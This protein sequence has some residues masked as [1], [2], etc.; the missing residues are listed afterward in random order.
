MYAERLTRGDFL[1]VNTYGLTDN[2]YMC[3]A[4]GLR[5]WTTERFQTLT[6]KMQLGAALNM[7]GVTEAFHEAGF[8]D[9]TVYPE[10][11]HADGFTLNQFESFLDERIRTNDGERFGLAFT[12][13]DRPGSHVITARAWRDAGS[14]R[15]FLST[16]FQLAPF[17]SRRFWTDIPK[18][19]SLSIGLSSQPR[20]WESLGKL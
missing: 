4:A 8:R 19:T 14:I 20:L 10:G 12:H 13:G 7:Q 11:H 18:A 5:G 16:D 15:R 9:I 6:G 2:C 1:E 3:A 17:N